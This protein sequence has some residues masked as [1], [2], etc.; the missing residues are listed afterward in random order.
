MQLSSRVVA[1]LSSIYADAANC[2]LYGIP[3]YIVD[4]DKLCQFSLTLTL[5][6]HNASNKRKI[7]FHLIR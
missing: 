1:N 4:I 7:I 5:L 2:S 3:S 6:E